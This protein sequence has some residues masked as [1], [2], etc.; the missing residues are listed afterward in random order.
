[1]CE[2]IIYLSKRFDKT[3]IT[4][5]HSYRFKLNITLKFN[6]SVFMP[7]IKDVA[8]KAGVSLSTVSLVINGKSN[9]TPE[10]RQK[11]ETII[12]ELNFHPRRNARGLAS[13]RTNNIGFIL[14]EDHFS[15]A[16]PFYTKI[17]LGTEFEARKHN[18]YIL[19]TTIPKKF[20]EHVD[21]PRFILERNVDGV[22]LAGKVPAKL[23]KIV[24][25]AKLPF[26]L[27]DYFIPS[28]TTSRILIDNH[29]GGRLAVEHL[30]ELGHK[31]IAFIGGEVNHPSI[32]ARLQGYKDAL[33]GHGL[34]VDERLISC[35]EPYTGINSGYNATCKLFGRGVQFT[36]IFA[37]N[38]T[39]ATGAM[40]CLREKRIKI[41][42]NVSIIGFDDI[43]VCLQVEPRLS[44]IRVFKEELGATAVNRMVEKINNNTR[45]IDQALIPVELVVRE[46]T[47]RVGTVD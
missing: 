43:E 19:L 44:T 37:S 32:N 47:G 16:E 27:I 18:Y 11:I 15:R 7:T 22:I 39:V 2:I 33:S 28:Q 23:I 13:K 5:F 12:A 45:T 1:V 14:T 3:N 40:R 31:K 30:I 24:E 8:K 26:I 29:Q 36:A 35:D 20:N 25:D 10:T 4:S 38:D 46:S 9:V 6:E 34:P 21:V 17:F 42:Q 41:P